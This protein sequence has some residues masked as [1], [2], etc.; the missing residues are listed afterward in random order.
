MLHL[1]SG[2]IA[3]GKSLSEDHWLSRLYPGFRLK[4]IDNERSIAGKRGSHKSSTRL[5][6][7]DIAVGAGLPAMRPAQTIEP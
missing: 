5:K 3:S 7:G 1:I 2:K 4:S 6:A